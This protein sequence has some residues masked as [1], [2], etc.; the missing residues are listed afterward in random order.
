MRSRPSGGARRTFKS[1]PKCADA[2]PNRAGRLRGVPVMGAVSNASDFWV[3]QYR[4]GR[5]YVNGAEKMPNASL[6]VLLK[7]FSWPFKLSIFYDRAG[8]NAERS[9]I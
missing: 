4:A 7:A 2:C 5:S 3:Q 9:Y 1:F 8:C 6:S